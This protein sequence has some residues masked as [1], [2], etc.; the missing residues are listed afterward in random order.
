MGLA[1]KRAPHPSPTLTTGDIEGAQAGARDKQQAFLGRRAAAVQA[2]TQQQAAQVVLA[3]LQLGQTEL[4]LLW[5]ECSRLDRDRSGFLTGARG[6]EGKGFRPKK[7]FRP[8]TGRVASQM[9]K[10]R[11]SKQWGHSAE[12]TGG[13]QSQWWSMYATRGRG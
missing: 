2:C 11:A 13:L 4:Q 1:T 6:C 12:S 3:G 7:G 8:R 9:P 10:G 5:R